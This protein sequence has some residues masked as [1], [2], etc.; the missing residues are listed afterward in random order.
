MPY[1]A[2]VSDKRREPRFGARIVARIVRRGET[3]D[4]LTNDVSFKGAFL[5]TDSAPST[6]QLVKVEL[7]LPGG[8][9]V[10]GHAMVVHVTPP[11]EGNRVPGVG[12]QFWG[13]LQ[14]GKAWESFI[15]EL[16]LKEKMGVPAARATDKVRR[17]SERFRLQL[18]VE[19]GGKTLVTRDV[20][21][22]GMAVRCSKPYL[23]IGAR[24]EM[25]V[26]APK[27]PPTML[28]VVVRRHIDEPSFQGIGVEFT[29]SSNDSRSRI[30]ALVQQHAPEEEVIYIDP[31]DPGLH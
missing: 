4:L 20:S 1:S 18:E 11:G 14:N 2:A 10:S 28:E 6:R 29:D 31:D 12:L 8:G 3:L 26:K 25:V 9:M 7:V 16:R 17:A 21:M 30:V 24:A 23:P 22:N 15:H 27:R 13:P 5:R 19:L